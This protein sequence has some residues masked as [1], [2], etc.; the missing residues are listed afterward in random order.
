MHIGISWT[1]LTAYVEGK[2][3]FG[4]TFI[5]NNKKQQ[6]FPAIRTKNKFKST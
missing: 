2:A 6:M 5:Y 4:K 3:K 1:I